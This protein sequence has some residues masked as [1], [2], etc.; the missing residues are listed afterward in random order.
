VNGVQRWGGEQRPGRRGRGENLS[1]LGLGGGVVWGMGVLLF[2]GLGIRIG[3]E[4]KG[5]RRGKIWG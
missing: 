3:V 1:S 2:G 5:R 4:I